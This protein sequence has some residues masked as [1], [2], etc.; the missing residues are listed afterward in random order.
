MKIET[1]EA[2]YHHTIPRNKHV[3]TNLVLISSEA[4]ELL[5]MLIGHQYYKQHDLIVFHI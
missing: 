3:K 2:C 5:I 4:R 1:K